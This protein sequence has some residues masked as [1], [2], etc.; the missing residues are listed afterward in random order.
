MISDFIKKI[1][2]QKTD[3][4]A[5]GFSGSFVTMACHNEKELFNKIMLV[6]PPSLTQLKQMPNRKDRLLKAALEIPIF[7]TLVYHMIVSR[8]N[9]N[10]LFI[11]KYININICHA[12]K[13]LDNS[14]YIVEG[15]TEP[16]GKAVTDDY[17]ASNP[18]IEVS[19]LKET[20]H[21]P[22]VEA[23]EAFLEQVKIFF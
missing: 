19:V 4:I 21:L 8:D 22:H 6:N 14:I 12:L 10:N 16:N 3:V 15:E 9:I 5:S 1:I 11:E 23:P 17:C 2:G 13:A 7:G 20:K 18:A